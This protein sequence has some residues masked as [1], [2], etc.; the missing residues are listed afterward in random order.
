MDCEEDMHYLLLIKTNI[1][2]KELLYYFEGLD[3]SVRKLNEHIKSNGFEFEKY[4][5][6]DFVRE[7]RS[8]ITKVK[9]DCYNEIIPALGIS[10]GDNFGMERLR[11]INYQEILKNKYVVL[12][13][14]TINY[15]STDELDNRVKELINKLKLFKSGHIKLL[16]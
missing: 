15:E 7:F 11:Y 16:S 10:Y 5:L 12:L 2:T 6:N 4:N 13:R 8:L 9:G 1:M 14:D 3:E